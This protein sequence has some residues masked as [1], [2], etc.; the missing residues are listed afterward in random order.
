MLHSH[1]ANWLEDRRVNT[2]RWWSAAVLVGALAASAFNQAYDFCCFPA[3]K[4]T[5]KQWIR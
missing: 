4:S 3:D 1:Y 5:K 2:G